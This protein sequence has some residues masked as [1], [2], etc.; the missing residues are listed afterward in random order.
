LCKLT[1]SAASFRILAFS[2]QKMAQLQEHLLYQALPD[3][4]VRL[5]EIRE[6]STPESIACRLHVHQLDQC[7]PYT[8]LSYTWG[9]EHPQKNI[10]VD[11]KTFSIREN[12]HDFLR[13]TIEKRGKQRR[14]RPFPLYWI[15][16]IC[17]NQSNTSER[18]HQVKLM[19]DLYSQAELVTIWLG[20]AAND[21][22]LAMKYLRGARAAM[23]VRH[24]YKLFCSVGRILPPKNHIFSS[25]TGKAIVALCKR[26]YWE[27]VWIIQEVLL[28]QHSI[29]CC[30]FQSITWDHFTRTGRLLFYLEEYNARHDWAGSKKN[31]VF[32]QGIDYYLDVSK[33]SK[34]SDSRDKV[35]G[36]LGLARP[37]LAGER[38]EPDYSK[39]NREVYE[40][41]LE[42]LVTEDNIYP[43][44]VAHLKRA[45]QLEFD[46]KSDPITV[47][48]WR[49][50]SDLG[51]QVYISESAHPLWQ[52]SR[53]SLVRKFL[54]ALHPELNMQ[55]TSEF[56]DATVRR[57]II[58]GSHMETSTS[59]NKPL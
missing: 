26:P 29:V 42:F 2:T 55:P 7:P 10:L 50:R 44:I 40:S 27:R 17:I 35:Y 15:D 48:F 45:L 3:S 28:A 20:N 53:R 51:L 18:N 13:M 32:N 1:F 6:G 41:V 38:L 54:Y 11:G 39:S 49:R 16:Q 52:G 47:A 9:A 58:A 37:N 36:L 34:S 22:D 30:G 43:D 56:N 24:F 46:D 14:Q 8:A 25:Q 57:N 5:L 33:S 12:L 4:S 19:A 31:A 59:M 23:I 21:S